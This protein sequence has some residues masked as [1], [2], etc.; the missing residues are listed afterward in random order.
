MRNTFISNLCDSVRQDIFLIVGDVGF[1]VIEKFVTTRPDKYLNAGVAEQ[2]MTGVAAG[3]ALNGN[4]VYTYSIANFNTMRCLEQ[5]RNDICYHNLDVTIVSVGGGFLYGS[6]GYSHHAVQD[7]AIMGMLP[8][9]TLL[10]PADKAEV[11]L[12]MEYSLDYGGPKYLRL[13]KNNEQSIHELGVKPEK[14]NIFNS[15]VARADNLILTIGTIASLA[16]EVQQ[17]LGGQGL[18]IDVGTCPIIDSVFK[19]NI[20]KIAEGYKTIFVLEEHIE[21]FG[22]ASIV[23]DA[24]QDLDTRVYSIGVKKDM[25]KIVGNQ[26]Y[27]RRCHGLDVDSVAEYIKLKFK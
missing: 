2:N 24:T 21:G 19:S 1:S 20:K 13:G 9:M 16:L 23:K 25:P 7:V 12:C 22:F 6:A 3:L 10:L 5:I 27:L 11:D 26:A 18:T 15:K 17:H 8:N 14:I 4:K